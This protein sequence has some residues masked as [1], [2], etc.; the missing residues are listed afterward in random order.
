MNGNKNQLKNK[1]PVKCRYCPEEIIF[2]KHG[3]KVVPLNYKEKRVF[4]K[5]QPSGEQV[6]ACMI[7]TWKSKFVYVIH[8]CDRKL[9]NKNGNRIKNR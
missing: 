9:K 6:A 2:I 1:T 4:I 3:N 7:G 5:V 8:N